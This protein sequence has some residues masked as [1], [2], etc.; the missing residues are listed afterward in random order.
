[1]C[2]RPVHLA[3]CAKFGERFATDEACASAIGLAV[4]AQWPT[5]ETLHHAGDPDGWVH[6]TTPDG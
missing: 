2:P 3:A 6:P 5:Y 1:M 4:H